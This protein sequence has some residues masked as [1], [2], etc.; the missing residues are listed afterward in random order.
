MTAVSTTTNASTVS[1]SDPPPD[2]RS[3][4]AVWS[5]ALL[6]ALFDD[7]LMAP[8]ALDQCSLTDSMKQSE[9]NARQKHWDFWWFAKFRIIVGNL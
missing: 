7:Q 6:Y 2:F 9:R 5:F 3:V 8:G 1:V 4:A